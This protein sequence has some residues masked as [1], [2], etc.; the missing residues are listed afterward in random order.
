MT[1]KESKGKKV[2]SAIDVLSQVTAQVRLNRADHE[3]VQKALAYLQEAT[4]C[5]ECQKKRGKK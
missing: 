3:T 4:I 1:K 5:L 2:Q